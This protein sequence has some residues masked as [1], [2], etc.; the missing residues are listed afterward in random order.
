MSPCSDVWEIEAEERGS[1][2]A[3]ELGSIADLQ[4]RQLSGLTPLNRAYRDAAF[5]F[6]SSPQ[7]SSP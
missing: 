4:N 1:K 3:R 5:Y 2:G 7:S 6:W